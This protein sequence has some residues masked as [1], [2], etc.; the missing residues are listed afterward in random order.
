MPY[1]TP[2][3]KTPMAWLPTQVRY[4]IDTSDPEPAN[5]KPFGELAEQQSAKHDQAAANRIAKAG[6]Q[7]RS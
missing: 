7:E 6:Q 3:P 5:W 1:L 2:K 4:G